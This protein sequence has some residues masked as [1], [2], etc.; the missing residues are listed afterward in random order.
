MAVKSTSDA[1]R[2]KKGA[3]LEVEHLAEVTG[4]TPKQA[5]ALLRKHGADWQRL[6]DEAEDLKKED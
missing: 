6:K 2:V 5:R 4:V 1:S 3:E